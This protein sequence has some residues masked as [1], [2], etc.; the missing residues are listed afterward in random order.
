[1]K[2]MVLSNISKSYFWN[3]VRFW[4]LMSATLSNAHNLTRCEVTVH[5][6][7]ICIY[8]YIYI[9][10]YILSVWGQENHFSSNFILCSPNFMG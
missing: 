3:L 8:I 2:F 7:E 10:I 9:N 6:K 1:M 4:V 5:N